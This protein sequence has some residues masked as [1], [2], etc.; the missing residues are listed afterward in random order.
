VISVVEWIVGID[1]GDAAVVEFLAN[2]GAAIQLV[3][4]CNQLLLKAENG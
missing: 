1:F 4:K 3:N 2:D